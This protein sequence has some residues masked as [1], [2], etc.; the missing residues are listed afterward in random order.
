MVISKDQFDKAKEAYIKAKD[1][2][3][4]CDIYFKV[5]ETTVDQKRSKTP[6]HFWKG[7]EKIAVFTKYAKLYKMRKET[8]PKD[9][10]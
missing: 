10:G 1:N 3:L 7:Q 8:H 9:T 6:G 4:Y 5:D 2:D